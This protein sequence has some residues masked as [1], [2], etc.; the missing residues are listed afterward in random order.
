MTQITDYKVSRICQLSDLS[1]DDEAKMEA[2]KAELYATG[3]K[4][5]S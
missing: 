2:A 3:I 1:V 5:C 4:K